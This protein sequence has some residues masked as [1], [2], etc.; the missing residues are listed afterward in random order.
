MR[1]P[2]DIS[3]AKRGEL[4]RELVLTQSTRILGISKFELRLLRFFDER[5]IELFTYGKDQAVHKMMKEQVRYLFLQSDLVRKSIFCLS[6]MALSS[7]VDLEV[8]QKIDILEDE[9]SLRHV[10]SI[11]ERDPNSLYCKNLEYFIGAITCT[12]KLLE[13][14]TQNSFKAENPYNFDVAKQLT[15]S[16][17]LIFC[18]MGITPHKLVPII[19]FSKESPDMI[20]VAKGMREAVEAWFPEVFQSEVG[21][22]LRHQPMMNS[23]TPTLKTCTYPIIV[24]LKRGLQEYYSANEIS[25]DISEEIEY[26]EEAINLLLVC[27]YSCKSLELPSPIYR[28]LFLLS[29]GIRDLLYKK[30]KYALRILFIYSALCAIAKCCFNLPTNV[31]RDFML[32]YSKEGYLVYEMDSKLYD[33]VFFENFGGIDFYQ[34]DTLDPNNI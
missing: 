10:Y 11:N 25:S 15:I 7:I 18:Y 6:A 31:Y 5:C 19:D 29:D 32:W 30:H 17:I 27:I 16:S 23:Q 34:Y 2:T 24:N 22:I 9:R 28:F 33:A 3:V 13:A 8:A 4:A 14:H 26:L 21:P 20:Q 1:V 12:R